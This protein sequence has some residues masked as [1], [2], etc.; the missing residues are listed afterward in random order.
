M[1]IATPVRNQE[2]WTAENKSNDP[3][4]GIIT[5]KRG[6]WSARKAE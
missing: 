4:D 3:K 5:T 6:D 2:E 1:E